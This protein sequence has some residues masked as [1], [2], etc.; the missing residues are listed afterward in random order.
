MEYVDLD[1]W[2]RKEHFEFFRRMDYPQYNICANIDVTNFL[3]F[4]RE[5]KFSFYYA[6]IH[7]STH[8]ANEI[9][10]FRYRIRENQVVLHDKLHP[11]F[12]DLNNEEDDLFKIVTVEMTDE[13]KDDI[14][15]FVKYSEEKSKNEN[16]YFNLKEFAGRDDLIYVT[17]IPW[18]SFTHV[19]HPISL[20][21]NDSVPRISWGKYFSENDKVLLPFSVQVN[22]ALVDGVH[23]GRYF[24]KLQNYIDNL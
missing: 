7:S 24:Q 1:N 8:I 14:S 5:R 11:S 15:K 4:V 3:N 18:I 16:E 2:K 13:M 6:M 23:V 9:I 22:H 12:T 10:N 21:K 20:N 17:C 19:S